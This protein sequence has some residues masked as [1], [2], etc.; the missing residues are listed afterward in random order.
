MSEVMICE[1]CRVGRCHKTTTP[2]VYWAGKQMLVFPNAPATVCDVCKDTMYDAHFLN[3][4]EYLLT[5]LT[6]QARSRASVKVGAVREAA[7]GWMS[8][9]SGR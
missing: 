7:N 6:Q 8:T 4:M 2:Y 9:R 5:D 3:Q 1:E